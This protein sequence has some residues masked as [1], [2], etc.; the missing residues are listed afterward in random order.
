MSAEENK[1]VVRRFIED[2][3]STGNLALADE[4]CAPNYV[5]YGLPPGIL[6][7]IEGI[8]QTLGVFRAAFPD[9]HITLEDLI[10]EEDKVVARFTAHGTHQGDFQG[11]PPTGKSFTAPG[12]TYYRIVNG[13]IAEDHPI[14]DQLGMLQ[15]LG[16]VPPLG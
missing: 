16:V 8:K 7:G 5:N 6:P 10:A 12:M 2:L 1:A 9:F 3:I 4:L 14:F 15:Q 11:I 13:K